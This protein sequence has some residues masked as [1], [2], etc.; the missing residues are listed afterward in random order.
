M[1]SNARTNFATRLQEIDQILDAHRA[2]LQFHRANHA[3][4]IGTGLTGVASVVNHLVSNPGPGRPPQIQ[5][6]NKAAIALLSGHFQGF[7]TDLYSE[8]A[9][10]LLTGHLGNPTVAIDAAPTRGNPNTKN[11][12]KLFST[13]GFPDIL[14]GIAWQNCTNHTL[15]TRLND[16]NEL[17]NDIVHGQSITVNKDVVTGYLSPWTAL[18]DRL[19]AKLRRE[20]HAI[21]G[22]YPW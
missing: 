19:D 13:L 12:K 21:K 3:A 5:A 15:R 6:L 14:D 22:V 1:P 17:R 8:A 10:H 2:L 11:I 7:V 4:T 20:I 16:F 18:A 9:I